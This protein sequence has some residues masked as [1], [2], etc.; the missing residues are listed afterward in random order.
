M[1]PEMSGDKQKSRDDFDVSL[2]SAVDRI[3]AAV[4]PL[5]IILF[6]SRANGDARPDSDVDLLVIENGSFNTRHSRMNEISRIRLALSGF[7]YPADILLRT[8]EEIE[9]WRDSINNI[10]GRALRSGRIL[11]ER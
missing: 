3:V 8:T 11:Y 5:C 4:Q 7:N 9:Y 6:G 10:V 1:N 2:S